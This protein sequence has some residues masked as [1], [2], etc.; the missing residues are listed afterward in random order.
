M[1][2]PDRATRFW[3]ALAVASLWVVSVGSAAEDAL[4]PSHLDAL[5]LKHIARRRAQR[6]RARPTPRPVSCFRR[7]LQTLVAAGLLGQPLPLGRFVPESWSTAPTVVSQ[8]TTGRAA[9]PRQK[10]YP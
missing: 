6:A 4:P 5:P 7:G 9:L 10:T 2:D 3:L 1:S 8:A